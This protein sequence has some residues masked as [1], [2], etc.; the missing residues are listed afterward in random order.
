MI[1]VNKDLRAGMWRG[2]I[3]GTMIWSFW[4]DCRVPAR[5]NAVDVV[6]LG[7]GPT[8]EHLKCYERSG[9]ELRDQC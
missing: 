7:L 5:G 9:Y 6:E 8:V 1:H 3:L 4:L 2:S